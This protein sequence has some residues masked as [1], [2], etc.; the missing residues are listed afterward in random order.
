[1]RSFMWLCHLIHDW[2]YIL[3]Q[4]RLEIYCSTLLMGP[5]AGSGQHRHAR[6]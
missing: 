1:M 4:V 6:I 3:T 2:S 5:A